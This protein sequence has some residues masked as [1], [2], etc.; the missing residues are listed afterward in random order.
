MTSNY[1]LSGHAYS[2][3]FDNQR[4]ITENYYDL[5]HG[6]VHTL[7]KAVKDNINQGGGFG[8]ICLHTPDGTNKSPSNFPTT[9]KPVECRPAFIH[10]K[11]VQ[12]YK[13][14]DAGTDDTNKNTLANAKTFNNQKYYAFV[15]DK[16]TA[17]AL[18]NE[19]NTFSDD[20]GI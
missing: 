8:W 3:E 2:T 13:E 9:D 1:K 7:Q 15:E 12:R 19:V 16:L 17:V 4:N 5:T 10:P 14:G 18:Q 20:L 6:Q 11:L